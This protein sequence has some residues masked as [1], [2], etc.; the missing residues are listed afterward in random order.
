MTYKLVVQLTAKFADELCALCRYVHGDVKPENFL[1][2]PPDSPRANKLYVV[3]LGLGMHCYLACCYPALFC[4]H[5]IVLEL[6]DCIFRHERLCCCCNS[7]LRRVC[8]FVV[9]LSV[10]PA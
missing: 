4:R 1:L 10:L 8:P 5:V 7:M 6:A 9:L 3:D 2:G